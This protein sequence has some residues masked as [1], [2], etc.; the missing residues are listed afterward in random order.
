[1]LSI[2]MRLLAGA[3]HVQGDGLAQALQQVPGQYFREDFSLH[4]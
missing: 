3:S 4:R 2:A 1:M